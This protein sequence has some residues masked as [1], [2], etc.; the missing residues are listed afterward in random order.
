MVLRFRFVLVVMAISALACG[1]FSFG[2]PPA[3]TATVVIP[4]TA[5]PVPTRVSMTSTPRS[6]PSVTPSPT[7]D[8]QPV[9]EGTPTSP[10]GGGVPEA[11]PVPGQPT[12]IV[13]GSLRDG[14][15]S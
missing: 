2:Q 9:G 6:G 13:M 11:T 8:D 14:T 4:P 3:P 1:S 5:P 7:P 10:P 15:M 12:E